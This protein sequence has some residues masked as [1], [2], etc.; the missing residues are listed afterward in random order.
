VTVAELVVSLLQMGHRVRAQVGGESM[1]PTIQ[2]GDT[3]ILEPLASSPSCDDLL[4]QIV[5][6]RDDFGRLRLHRLVRRCPSDPAR[7]ITRGDNLAS[8]DLPRDASQ[9]LGRVVR[10]ER[11]WAR[12]LLRTAQNLALGWAVPSTAKL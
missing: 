10:V 11:S 9:L 1:G 4:G 6:C 2:S 7:L 5:L 12:R 3:V 8:C